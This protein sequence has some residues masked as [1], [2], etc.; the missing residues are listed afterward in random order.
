MSRA[1][2]TSLDQ[3]PEALNRVHMGFPVDVLPFAVFHDLVGIS[4]LLD[5]VVAGKLVRVN[6]VSGVSRNTV[7]DD[8]QDSSRFHVSCDNG[9]NMAFLSVCEADNGRFAQRAASW[10][11][12]MLPAIVSLIGFDGAVHGSEFL[13]H[14]RPNLLKHSPSRLI[15]H[16]KLSLKLFGGDTTTGRGHEKHGVE[17]RPERGGRLM[18]DRASGGRNRVAT[19]LAVV[20]LSSRPAIVFRDLVAR[21][22]VSPFGVACLEDELQA[23]VVVRELL[24][25][26]LDRVASHLS[27]LILFTSH[28]WGEFGDVGQ[29]VE[30]TEC[31]NPNSLP[32][33]DICPSGFSAVVV[34]LINGAHYHSHL[35]PGQL[36]PVEFRPQLKGDI[37]S[38]CLDCL[39]SG[40]TRIRLADIVFNERVQVRHPMICF[41]QTIAAYILGTRALAAVNQVQSIRYLYRIVTGW[42]TTFAALGFHVVPPLIY[43]YLYYTLILRDVKG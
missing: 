18:E 32:I 36:A 42:S 34:C 15:G 6:R 40:E 27:L 16:S 41:V 26:L 11:T 43:L 29:L 38:Y 35:S 33:N 13:G 21:Q 19:E 28:R 4:E 39:P 9:L 10:R 22:A 31:T 23:R 30:M 20:R 5:E 2:N 37:T 14:Q 1:V 3:R 25:E 12:R 8:W 7:P 24:V 17:P